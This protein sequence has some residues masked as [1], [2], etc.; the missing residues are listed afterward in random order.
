MIPSCYSD[1][2][3]QFKDGD[4]QAV[5]FGIPRSASTFVWQF[6]RDLLG[7]GVVKTHSFLDV[8]APVV[9]TIR[10]P[11]DV[12]VSYW[13]WQGMVGNPTREDLVRLAGMCR[14]WFWTLDRYI[15][16]GPVL[17]LEFS[18]LVR[19]PWMWCREVC[20]HVGKMQPDQW[21]QDVAARYSLTANRER[22]EAAGEYDPETQLHRE[23]CHEGRP[24]TWRKF[25][26]GEDRELLE[27][28]LDEPLTKWG[29]KTD[30]EI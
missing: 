21:I 13:R 30:D 25:V 6:T 3:T 26:T 24:G 11:R 27:K 1:S 14:I 23:H 2:S 8:A 4:V 12:V 7:D 28:L 15:D 22:S 9:V 29:Y 18:D 19:H 16:R 5:C 20:K 17:L 10:D